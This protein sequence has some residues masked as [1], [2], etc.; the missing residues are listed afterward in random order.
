MKW[1][2]FAWKNVMRNRR[3]SFT[4]MLITALGTAAV[5]ASGGFALFTYESLEEMTARGASPRA[6]ARNRSRRHR[7][8]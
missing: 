5:L 7:A 3:R 8:W 1:L 2:M 6:A 4:A